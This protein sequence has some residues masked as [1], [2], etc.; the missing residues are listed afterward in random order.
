MVFLGATRTMAMQSAKA[1]IP[2]IKFRYGNRQAANQS[3]PAAA[4]PAPGGQVKFITF[5]K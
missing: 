4:T 5:I 3:A 2:L 1:R